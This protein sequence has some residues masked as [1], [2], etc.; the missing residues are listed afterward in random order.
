LAIQRS[1]RKTPFASLVAAAQD[2]G[3]QD[4]GDGQ[5]DKD[6]DGGQGLPQRRV[7]VA[8]HALTAQNTRPGTQHPPGH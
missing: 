2:R 7:Q 5:R 3:E 4:H 8:G 1:S 6:V